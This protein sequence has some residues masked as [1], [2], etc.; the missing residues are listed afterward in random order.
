MGYP[1]IIH[2]F[3]YVFLYTIQLLGYP[4]SWKPESEEIP[5]NFG[6]SATFKDGHSLEPR[7][8][9][10]SPCQFSV[11]MTWWILEKELDYES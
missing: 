4:H 3:K 11:E 9:P 5:T 7:E 1:H 8:S 6:S 10:M 2:F